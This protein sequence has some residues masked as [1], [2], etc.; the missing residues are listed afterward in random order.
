MQDRNDIAHPNGNIFFSNQQSADVKIAEVIAQMEAIQTHMQPIIHDC[1]CRFLMDSWDPEERE[2]QDTADQIR[3]TLIHANYLSQKDIES[4]L[5][6]N[7]S[8]LE[9]EDNYEEMNQLFMEFVNLY[10]QE[11]E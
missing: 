10:K 2:Y 9:G 4:C 5:E 11:E 3:E 8:S 7:I 1:L 6:F